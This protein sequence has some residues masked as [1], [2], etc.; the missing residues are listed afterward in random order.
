[1]DSI[2]W[3]AG[4]S[5]EI[6]YMGSLTYHGRLAQLTESFAE[7]VDAFAAETNYDI[8]ILCTY[9]TQEAQNTL[10]ESGATKLRFPKS[11]HN[12]LPSRAIDMAP[13]SLVSKYSD[14]LE[15]DWEDTALFYYF[16]GRF[17]QFCE[18][19]YGLVI[20]WG[21]DWDMDGQVKDNSFN[22][23]VHFEIY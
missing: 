18:D 16:A 14:S 11:K 22:D 20:R 15:V 6:G 10:F 8:V 12:K 4:S 3:L 1:M 17:V 5:K 7:A 21:G 19:R 23:L 13:K 2:Y 9:R